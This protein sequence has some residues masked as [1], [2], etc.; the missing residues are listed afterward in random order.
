MKFLIPWINKFILKRT[1]KSIIKT[2]GKNFYT[3]LYNG[4]V[5]KMKEIYPIIPSI[6]KSVFDSSYYVATCYFTWFPVLKNMNKTRQE[7][8][9]IIW[10]I[11]EEFM[12]EVPK[13]L[14]SFTG[15]YYVGRHKK[16]GPWA[17]KRALEGK[18][19]PDDWKITYEQIDNNAWKID[20][21]EC[22]IVK[23][24]KRLGQM[25]IFPYVCRMDYLFSHYFN[26]EFK[27]T[28]TLGDGCEKCD[29]YW[30][31]PGETDWP[32]PLDIEGMKVGTGS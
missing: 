2:Y 22:Y 20:I 16:L 9:E 3:Q 14:L 30:K 27:R 11:N 1:K 23:M 21:L 31:V 18:L 8:G 6:G 32:V 28:M 24:G 13:F 7:A 10:F 25:D 26:Q 29:C 17:A 4:S 12:K 15:K 5:K 19:H